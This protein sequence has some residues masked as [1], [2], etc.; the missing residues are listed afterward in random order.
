MNV[1]YG[2]GLIDDA[3]EKCGVNSHTIIE[4]HPDV[5]QEIKRRG[6][7]KL[8]GYHTSQFPQ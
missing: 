7:D 5:I 8:K 3:I 6:V 4:P 1:G 2:L